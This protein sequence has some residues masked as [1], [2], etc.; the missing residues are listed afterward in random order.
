MKRYL[1]I[2]LL[3]CVFVFGYS[4]SGDAVVSAYQDT[5][6]QV[7]QKE[8]FEEDVILKKIQQAKRDGD[9]NRAIQLM[10]QLKESSNAW[11][12]WYG[13]SGP[14]SIYRKLG[15]TDKAI[16]VARSIAKQ[17]PE[18]IGL[19]KLWEGDC[20]SF[21]GEYELAAQAYEEAS[22]KF[23]DQQV[24]NIHIGYRALQKLSFAY[25]DL[26]RP[27]L[28]ALALRN[29]IKRYPNQIV[30]KERTLVSINLLEA[31]H[32]GQLPIIPLRD[33]LLNNSSCTEESPCYVAEGF[34]TKTEVEPRQF[35][36]FKDFPGYR[37]RFDE[38]L[39]PFFD[40][41][42][43]DD[44][45]DYETKLLTSSTSA[46]T[47][48][49]ATDGFQDPFSY[50]SYGDLYMTYPA[51]ASVDS[52]NPSGYSYPQAYYGDS[53]SSY[54]YHPGVD[55][56][57]VGDCSMQFYSV[58]QGCVTYAET[59]PSSWGSVTVKHYYLPFNSST[60][61]WT[62]QYGHSDN[63]YV[64]DGDAVAKNDMLGDIDGIGS[65]GA[66]A[67]RAFDCHLHFE[68]RESDHPDADNASYWSGLSQANIGKY[69][70]HPETFIDSHTAYDWALWFDE[71]ASDW[72]YSGSWST[73][74]TVGNN[75][76]NDTN[77]L[78]YTTSDSSRS[79]YAQ[80]TFEAPET[81]TY[82]VWMF[83]PW[84][85]ATSSQV[86]V[87][88]VKVSDG[89]EEIN[90]T[91]NQA[92]SGSYCDTWF[93][94]DSDN[95]I[96]SSEWYA[97]ANC[98]EW[99]Q[100]GSASLTSGEDYYVEVN[101]NTSESGKYIAIDDFLIIHGS[102]TTSLGRVGAG[103]GSESTDA[104]TGID[105][106]GDGLTDYEESI[107]GTDPNDIDTDN[108]GVQDDAEV[109]LG[110]DPLDD[111]TDGDGV[112]D[113][114]DSCDFSDPIGGIDTFYSNGCCLSES[115]TDGDGLSDYTEI[116]VTGT[117]ETVWDTDGGG[118]DDGTED[119]A[120]T[121]PLD[122]DEDSD[123]VLEGVDDCPGSTDPTT[124]DSSGCDQYQQD[125]DGDGVDN[126]DDLCSGT[127]PLDAT[128]VNDGFGC[129]RSQLDSDGD[130]LTD[131]EELSGSQ[132]A[133]VYSNNET[134][135]IY[136]GKD[137]CDAAVYDDVVVVGYCRYTKYISASSWDMTGAATVYRWN[138]SYW[139]EEAFLE[140]SDGGN[141][142][143]FGYT[144][145]IYDDVIVVGAKE[146]DDTASNGG[147]AY[148][149]RY[150]GGSW[151]E[152]AKLESSDLAADDYFGWDVDIYDGTIVVG[153]MSHD[154]GG[155]F[156]SGAAY[157][158]EY[159]SGSWTETQE[160][161]PASLSS[162]DNVGYAV[163]IHDEVIAT[164]RDPYMVVFR[165]DSG[166]G[167]WV[168]EDEVQPADYSPSDH[169]AQK[170]DVYN[171][172][173]IATSRGD[174]DVANSAGAVY[175]YRYNST[176]GSWDEQD[177]VT[178]YDGMAGADFGVSVA[179]YDTTFVVGA[180]EHDND[181]SN[182]G[183]AYVYEYDD[184]TGES[185]LV[186]RIY[187]YD[188][189]DE[190]YLGQGVGI[191][192]DIVV[193]SAPYSE[194]PL[195]ENGGGA[196][197]VDLT[198]DGLR[199]DF[200]DEDTDDDGILDGDESGYGTD[201][202]DDD[203]DDDGLLDG[204]E[205][206]T[207]STDPL[208]SDSDSDGLTD[209]DEVTTYG[210]DPNDD[211]TDGDGIL[212][213]S[214]SLPLSSDNDGDGVDDSVDNC[215]GSTDLAT[216]DSNGCDD[217]QRDTDL[218]SVYDAYD[219]CPS[220]IV[221]DAY[222]VVDE[223]GCSVTQSLQLH[224]NFDDSLTTESSDNA[225]AITNNGAT[226]AGGVVVSSAELDGSSYVSVADD[227]AL[228]IQ[229]AMTI[230]FWVKPTDLSSRQYQYLFQRG[231][232]TTSGTQ[233]WSAYMSYGQ[234]WF[235]L[236][237]SD[238]AGSVFS[239]PLV[240]DAWTHVAFVYDG[241]EIKVYINANEYRSSAHTGTMSVTSR[242]MLLGCEGSAC[243]KG[244]YGNIDDFRVYSTALSEDVIRHHMHNSQDGLKV[245][246][247]TFDDGTAS[248]SGFFNLSGSANSTTA[249]TGI[250]GNGALTFDGST[251]YVEI[252]NRDMINPTEEVTV[253]VWI[254]PTDLS[255][256]TVQRVLKRGWTTWG[257]HFYN[258]LLIFQT[259][260]TDVGGS[261]VN[262]FTRVDEDEWHHVVGTYDGSTQKL[263]VNGRLINENAQSG[264][265][266]DTWIDL[267]IGANN[268]TPNQVFYG[269]ID[270]VKVFNYALDEDEVWNDYQSIQPD[271]I[272]DMDF[273]SG[274]IEDNTGFANIVT[275]TA[276]I[277][278]S[279]Y[280]GNGVEFTGTDFITVEN[281]DHLNPVDAVTVEAW[282][283][284]TDATILTPQ[285]IVNRGFT[286]AY[287]LY[288]Y[289]GRAFFYTNTSADGG[290]EIKCN[291]TITSGT[292]IHVAGTYDSATGE[293]KLFINGDE[294]CSTTNTGE[295]NSTWPDLVIGAKD[296]SGN[297][298]FIGSVDDVKIYRT[299]LTESEIET[300]AG[301]A[302]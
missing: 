251:S 278:T 199:T 66:S 255:A 141:G 90:T 15:K 232:S 300:D 125:D 179:L 152:E 134:Y 178:A 121:D 148:V 91:V 245:M 41:L 185:T 243:N 229:D 71:G 147:A 285:R 62:S 236:N 158:F 87:K 188:E 302:P 190:D 102:G 85:Y 131:Y 159:S 132:T 19:M 206:D 197:I 98:D 288:V 60:H 189:E 296:T 212:D 182:S 170:L 65:G 268:N 213:G 37:F 238:G 83:V 142:D 200:M 51:A 63:V 124:V 18:L 227:N 215:L 241:S 44:F 291:A 157:V 58:A 234:I 130:G 274:S 162:A 244:L 123:G 275:S 82:T 55:L 176:S 57:A 249:G 195:V 6:S 297:D 127:S 279:G 193:A 96:D 282:I 64:L 92:G 129:V 88:L 31:M 75:S 219:E 126:A 173:I 194:N 226:S 81:G 136:S 112:I 191:Y 259:D 155:T 34:V 266:D 94:D 77:D 74:S 29:L 49:N 167:S 40:R 10:S 265:L 150:S 38:L 45:L 298:A 273:D 149:Y 30:E 253:S 146:H 115:D 79:A 202:L 86:P 276:S 80:Y 17:R 73:V 54:A 301:L 72:S 104:A 101:N 290:A 237:T 69:Y 293:Q 151:T 186:K 280:S 271:K 89:T 113:G 250:D 218:D 36:K 154:H 105:S 97:G 208:S 111:D 223:S 198:D 61:Y 138:G 242:D 108:D 235:V 224:L 262:N 103:T 47:P 52:V 181:Y 240:E 252:D 247:L 287:G 128:D 5:E 267:T 109:T 217:Y 68:I 7:F 216:V 135:S 258:G 222:D 42:D 32:N 294:E 67:G 22:L 95:Y 209:Y 207:Y 137:G 165:Y 110:T 4:D 163:A 201:P 205:V 12:R 21:V 231:F 56:N 225:I 35:Q 239:S 269:D 53:H 27:D 16:E 233:T 3:V 289:N 106:D 143:D 261:K 76:S 260:T 161:L 257:I 120:G 177:K 84:N 70:Q 183:A 153:A 166:S 281:S 220:T 118:I 9:Y 192:G 13:L 116:Y 114:S 144:V 272:F 107:L 93:D 20:Y 299:A 117:D 256:A 164:N 246:H 8:F 59:S 187:A 221:A 139:E 39:K 196:Y 1:S 180:D 228:D 100:V 211:D 48:N 171:N 210:T 248:D 264:V 204:E 14:V 263:Y 230:E 254:R 26:K 24:D 295:I 145:A 140:P 33:A 292:W 78:K 283:N 25:L 203:Y 50:T 214:D 169:F 23:A 156:A 99:I 46:C 277:T 286:Y 174:D 184:S 28:S 284:V 122:P 175:V 270:D 11:Y 119:S 160:L 172:T 43:D 168:E 2:F 133:K